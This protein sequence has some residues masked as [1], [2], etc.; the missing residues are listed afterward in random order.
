MKNTEFYF[1][2]VYTYTTRL[3]TPLKAISLVFI[4]LIP[5][6]YLSHMAVGD[7]LPI[8]HFLLTCLLAIFS[9]YNIYELGY[10]QNDTE[11]IKHQKDPALRLSKEKIKYY[12]KNKLRIYIVRIIIWIFA[13]IL[14]FLSSP[15][16]SW[17]TYQAAL[18]LTLLLYQIYNRINNCSIMLIYFLLVT[19]RYI[20]P[21]LIFLPALNMQIFILAILIF[22]LNKT[23]EF[24]SEKSPDEKTNLFF[25]KYIIKF[26]PNNLSGYR[27]LAY[28][29]L[30]TLSLMFFC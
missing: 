5:V 30:F 17:L 13:S 14:L 23:L 15:I 1:P 22:P 16:I 12:D 24:R 20:A 28:G 18:I 11:A 3:R 9:Y 4:Y 27:V 8:P 29:V 26:N 10:I 19:I 6:L 21:V 2:F 25:R 7:V